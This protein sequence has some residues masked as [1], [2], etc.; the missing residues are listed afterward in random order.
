MHNLIEGTLPVGCFVKTRRR[1]V[2][3]SNTQPNPSGGITG[4]D[5]AIVF[6]QLVACIGAK[7]KVADA[8]VFE[9]IT[10]L[11]AQEDGIIVAAEKVHEPR[12]ESQP[13][14]VLM[15]LYPGGI[16]LRT[17]P[18]M[19]ATKTQNVLKLYECTNVQGIISTADGLES[20]ALLPGGTWLPCKAPGGLEVAV[21]VPRSPSS[22][23]GNFEVTMKQD[24]ATL[25]GPFPDSP[26]LP[27]VIPKGSTILFDMLMWYPSPDGSVNSSDIFL[28]LKTD[29]STPVPAVW[30]RRDDDTM[31]IVERMAT[32]SA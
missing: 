2:L 1:V 25:Y 21:R 26:A 7:V 23:E 5:T 9:S 11:D 30:V 17:S 4:V 14:V 31:T 32:P 27:N 18:H 24:C 13:G 8:W 29:A 3:R 6:L 20:Y 19:S 10:D 22:R 16:T 28:R 12:V 15:V